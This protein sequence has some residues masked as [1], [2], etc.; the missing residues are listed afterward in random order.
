MSWYWANKDTIIFSLKLLKT[1]NKHPTTVNQ[2]INHTPIY[3]HNTTQPSTTNTDPAGWSREQTAEWIVK[4]I[5][6]KYDTEGKVITTQTQTQQENDENDD[7][8]KENSYSDAIV[9]ALQ[10]TNMTHA[11][12]YLCQ[13][14]GKMMTI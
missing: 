2:L 14:T 7:H 10:P 9:H 13:M 11:G 5:H 1:V 4:M 12:L 6:S 8:C 3:Q